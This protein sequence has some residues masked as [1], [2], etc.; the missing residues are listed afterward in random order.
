MIDM[1]PVVRTLAVRECVVERRAEEA[2]GCCNVIQE[3]HM[4]VPRQRGCVRRNQPAGLFGEHYS[5]NEVS[6]YVQSLIVRNHV[7]S[8]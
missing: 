5:S 3:P 8:K 1:T 7:E 4:K 2:D 6:Q